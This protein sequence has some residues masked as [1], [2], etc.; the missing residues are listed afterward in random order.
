MHDG[1][2]QIDFKFQKIKLK[3]FNECM[4]DVF[5]LILKIKKKLKNIR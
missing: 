3:I 1:C 5:K 2:L 4:M